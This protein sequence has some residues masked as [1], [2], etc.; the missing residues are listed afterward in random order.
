MILNAV[1]KEKISKKKINKKRGRALPYIYQNKLYLGERPKQTGAGVVSK[2]LG[3]ILE[4]VG[5]VIGL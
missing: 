1:P 5:D 2:T 4:T 3:R